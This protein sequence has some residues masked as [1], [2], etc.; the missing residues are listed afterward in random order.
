MVRIACSGHRGLPEATERL[1]A[2]ALVSELGART[3]ELVGLSCLADGADTLF[4]QALLDAGGTLIAG[5]PAAQYRAGLPQWHHAT[6][7]T[8]WARASELIQLDHVEST[9]ESHMAASERML[10]EADELV[11]VWDGQPARGYGGTADVVDT[12]KQH[13]VPVTVIWPDGATRD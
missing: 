9:S 11:A 8:L 4:A 13:G 1:V 7:D 12:A 6:Y 5:V 2:E 10:S 3:G